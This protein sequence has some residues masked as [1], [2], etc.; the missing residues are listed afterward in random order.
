MSVQYTVEA[1]ALQI[2]VLGN[3]LKPQIQKMLPVTLRD[4][5]QQFGDPLTCNRLLEGMQMRGAPCF[6]PG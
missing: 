5:V 4:G 2:V 3:L 1:L 6:A